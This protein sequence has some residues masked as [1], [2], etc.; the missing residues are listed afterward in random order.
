MEPRCETSYLQRVT[1]LLRLTQSQPGAS[2]TK[3]NNIFLPLQ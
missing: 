3:G 2:L 1:K